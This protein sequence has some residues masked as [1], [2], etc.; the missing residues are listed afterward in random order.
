[1]PNSFSLPLLENLFEGDEVARN[2]YAR[3]LLL[4]DRQELPIRILGQMLIQAPS[5]RGR[6]YVAECINRCATNQEI[7]KL[8]EFQLSK[9]IK[10]FKGPRAPLMSS[11]S[12]LEDVGQGSLVATPTTHSEAKK[13]SLIRDNYRCMLSGVA[14][15]GAIESLPWLRAEVKATKTNVRITQCCYIL[16]WNVGGDG[17]EGPQDASSIWNF[18]RLFG[19][20]PEHELRGPRAHDL[21]NILTL[22]R[23]V[24][25]SFDKFL[26]WLEATGE[27]ENQYTIGRIDELY[28]N[29]LPDVVTFSSSSPDLPLPDPRYLALH[30][31]CARVIKLSGAVEYIARIPSDFEET[32]VLSENGS[33]SKRPN[34][35]SPGESL[36]VF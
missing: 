35:L 36:A 1:M 7:V 10:Y 24:R 5:L 16:P 27:A 34:C 28:Y 30:A 26:I 4:E 22:E 13:Q 25:V 17:V 15:C 23:G 31:A 29:D 11:C 6:T 18:A 19:D 3:V 8:G 21:R 9:L 12:P 14:D 20:I 33:A 2:A 32:E